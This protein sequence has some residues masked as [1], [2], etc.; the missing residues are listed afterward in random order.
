MREGRGRSESEGGRERKG[1]KDEDAK[2]REE[3]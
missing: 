2:L 3:I 1:A